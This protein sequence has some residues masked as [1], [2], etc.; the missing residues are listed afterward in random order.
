M[1]RKCGVFQATS[2]PYLPVPEDVEE[3]ELEVEK[4]EPMIEMVHSPS[5]D[6]PADRPTK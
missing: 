6:M 3:P 5:E 2:L 1:P 4:P